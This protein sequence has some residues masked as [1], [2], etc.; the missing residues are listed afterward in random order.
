[1]SKSSEAFDAL[2]LAMIDTSAAC[3]ND[4]RFIDDEQAPAELAPICEACPLYDL[5]S[6]YAT[7]DRPKGGI[8]AGKRYTQYKVK[9][10]EQ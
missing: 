7:L 1:M 9:S 8:W 2:K 4:D 5:C 6:T 10:D 3:L